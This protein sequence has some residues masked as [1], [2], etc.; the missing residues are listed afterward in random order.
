MK[1]IIEMLKIVTLKLSKKIS[2]FILDLDVCKYKPCG[3]GKF[4]QAYKTSC[5][6]MFGIM[7]GES[8]KN[9]DRCPYCNKRTSRK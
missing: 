5:G 9:I 8:G 3:C 1:Q 4:M 6:E 7:I 2:D